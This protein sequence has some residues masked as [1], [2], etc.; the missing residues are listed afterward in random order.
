MG[1]PGKEKVLDL[2]RKRVYWPMMRQG[3]KKLDNTCKSCAARR[4]FR[5]QPRPL[6]M[7]LIDDSQLE[8]MAKGNH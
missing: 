2:L 1:H 4:D 5:Q 3:I 6:P 7:M 8:P